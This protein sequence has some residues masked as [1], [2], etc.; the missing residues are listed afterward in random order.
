MVIASTVPETFESGLPVKP[1]VSPV[2]A[3]QLQL[4][5]AGA[6]MIPSFP[7]YFWLM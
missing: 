4:H 5:C 2:A 1:Q 3:P 7:K 6:A